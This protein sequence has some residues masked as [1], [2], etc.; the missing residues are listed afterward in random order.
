MID[1]YDDQT[2]AAKA[3]NRAANRKARARG[4]HA[5]TR[6]PLHIG[7]GTQL[8]LINMSSSALPQL[9]PDSS[10]I[11]SGIILTMRFALH[12]GLGGTTMASW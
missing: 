2:T 6:A 3:P 5:R 12:R 8:P 7:S 1:V 11:G 4:S 9:P 10:L